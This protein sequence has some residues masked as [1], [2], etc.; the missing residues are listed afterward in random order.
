[1]NNE[2]K[3]N[4]DNYISSKS[5]ILSD[6]DKGE[7]AREKMQLE[8]LEKEYKKIIIVIPD[9][10]VSFNSS[11][12]LGL[13]TPSIKYLGGRVGFFNK[14]EFVCDSLIMEDIE[15]GIQ[16]ASHAQIMEQFEDI[17]IYNLVYV[18]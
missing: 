12:F 15:Y 8:Q 10:I 5:I 17:L 18:H 9:R 14:Y 2:K 6:R 13:F 4:I 16:E 7:L 3:I 1:M 11:Y